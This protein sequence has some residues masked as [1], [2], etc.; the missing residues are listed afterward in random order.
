MIRN[1]TLV[2]LLTAGAFAAVILFNARNTEKRVAQNRIEHA[3]QVAA[4]QFESRI[5]PVEQGL[6]MAWEWGK[7]GLIDAVRVDRV[8]KELT[9]VLRPLTKVSSVIVADA[10]G[11]EILLAANRGADG[12]LEGW[13]TRTRRPG[14][15]G[16]TYEEGRWNVEGRMLEKTPTTMEDYDPTTRPWFVGAIDH[17]PIE[18][19][20][21]SPPHPLPDGNAYGVSQSMRFQA[22]EAPPTVVAFDMLLTGLSEMVNEINVSEHGAAF[23]CNSAGEVFLPSSAST[24]EQPLAPVFV[25]PTEV[26]NPL[27]AAAMQA[28]LG[29]GTDDER[30]V[31]FGRGRDAGWA[32]FTL[33][34]PRS[35]LW[36][37]VAV[38]DEDIF[39]TPFEGTERLVWGLA[40]I[41]FLGIFATVYLLRGYGAKLRDESI[42]RV[43]DETFAEDVRALVARGEGPTIEFKSTVRRNLKTDKNS[44][45]I[46][47]AWLKGAVAFMNSDGGT[48]LIGV[49]D[50]GA[51]RGIEDDGFESPDR[52]Q[53]HLKNLVNQHIG[54]E[55]SQLIRFAVHTVDERSIV[56][57]ECE[58]S[59]RPVFLKWNNKDAF[60]IRSGPSSVELS[61]RQVLEYVGQRS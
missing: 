19:V 13:T 8:V 54:A 17:T 14:A 51:L 18:S 61:S 21:R 34:D 23:L 22:R 35:Q 26:E 40:A 12:T 60:F 11:R 28:W 6:T 41:L 25:P 59:S 33:L 46:E 9:P 30:P 38:P 1:L 27:V 57:V 50:D 29:D 37:G 15:E 42:T 39:G 10:D 32:G 43:E 55:F 53:L 44:K 24:P 20:F 4:E 5:S 16:P 3:T 7:M 45:D 31:H 2:V 52:C 49:G 48:L 47:L 36:M 56:V 58:R